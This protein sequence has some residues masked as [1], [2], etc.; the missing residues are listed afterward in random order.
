MKNK[1]ALSATLAFTLL[2]AA[3][4]PRAM[5]EPVTEVPV[6][7]VP[8]T[9]VP[10]TADPYA[11]SGGDATSTTASVEISDQAIENGAVTVAK[12]NA[13]VD[14]W[15]VIHVEADGKPGPV[16]G[17]AQVPAG[18]S[19]D[20]KVTIDPTLATTK[21]FAMLHVDEGIKGTYEFPGAD[22]PVKDG[23]I[24]VMQA[25]NQEEAW[26]SAPSVVAI[27]QSI[28]DGTVTIASAFM[29]VPGWMVIHIEADG[30]PGPV[31]GYVQL[32][33]GESKDIIVTIDASQVTP[34]LFAMLHVD[35]GVAGTYEF[36]GDDAPVKDGDAIVM[37]PF[38]IK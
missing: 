22:A 7:E 23:E 8:A 31:I 3:C 17:Y 19:T 34:K 26:L 32:P 18:E 27:D 20:V 4:A 1:F 13:A 21:M 5:E 15:I 2:L 25:F 14:G 38:A 28:V 11:A 29:D 12:I 6:T 10:A 35:A 37:V 24:I 9:E 36:P 30:K 33:A 16:I